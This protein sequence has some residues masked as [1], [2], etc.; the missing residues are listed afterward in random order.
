MNDMRDFLAVERETA[1]DAGG[2]LSAGCFLGAY[3]V[4]GW[5][6]LRSYTHPPENLLSYRPWWRRTPA[7]APPLEVLEGRRHGMHLVARVAGVATREAASAMRG[8][9]L[10]V[11]RSCLPPPEPGR[12]YWCDL[13]GLVVLDDTGRN[14]GHVTGI[15]GT[16]AHDVLRVRGE[17]EH[18]VPMVPGVFVTSVDLAGGRMHVRTDG[19]NSLPNNLGTPD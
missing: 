6:R 18:L 13:L 8:V 11:E 3:G 19:L 14:L 12:Y 10:V 4:R 5:V 16:G 7:D 2:R 15:M 17:E 1:L 9:E